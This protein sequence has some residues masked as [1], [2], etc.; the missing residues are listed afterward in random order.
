M[1]DQY[2]Q[3]AAAVEGERA[4]E[5]MGAVARGLDAQAFI[6]GDLGRWMI[7]SSEKS[8]S[9]LVEAL[10]HCPPT[11]TTSIIRLQQEIWAIDH[12]KQEFANC[13]T[14]GLAAERELELLDTID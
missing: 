8:R 13:I 10:V 11:D 4:R 3:A 6:E 7:E 9:E 14:A 5:L 12:W 1:T 2:Q